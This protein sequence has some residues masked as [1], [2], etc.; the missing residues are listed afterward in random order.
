MDIYIFFELIW[1]IFCRGENSV[2]WLFRTQFVFRA[3]EHY[4]SCIM[5]LR[6]AQHIENDEALTFIRRVRACLPLH[7]SMGAIRTN[8]QE[9]QARLEIRYRFD[10][11]IFERT[12]ERFDQFVRGGQVR[13]RFLFSFLS[14]R[15]HVT[16]HRRSSALL[17][18]IVG[19][20]AGTN[21]NLCLGL[22]L[23][24]LSLAH[25]AMTVQQ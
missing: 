15:A 16:L 21:D 17:Q 19:V 25:D 23:S 24:L 12:C 5:N 11:N 2:L 10:V 7:R 22:S 9:V 3:V 6:D 20:S 14:E 13:F 4:A 1:E 18:R 8:S